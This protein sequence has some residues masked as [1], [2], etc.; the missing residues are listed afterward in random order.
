ML[1]I[2]KA[3]YIIE[4]IGSFSI[5]SARKDYGDDIANAVQLGNTQ[6]DFDGS[7]SMDDKD[8]FTKLHVWTKNNED[9]NLQRL[10]ISLCGI[11]LKEVRPVKPF[12]EYVE[13]QYPFKFFRLISRGRQISSVW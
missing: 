12:Y 8:G 2:E 13:N 5:L 1:D 9:G 6:P 11:M 3:E 10:D 7:E 4:E